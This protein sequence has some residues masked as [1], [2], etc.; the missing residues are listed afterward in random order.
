MI[1]ERGF[2]ARRV[3]RFPL[4]LLMGL[5]LVF[6][7]FSSRPAAA[8]DSVLLEE[9]RFNLEASLDQGELLPSPSQESK[10]EAARFLLEEARFIFSGMLY[11]FTFDYRP[12]DERFE[13][14]DEFSLTPVAGIP[15]GDEALSI[16]ESRMEDNTL[17]VQIRYDMKPFQQRRREAWDSGRIPSAAGIGAAPF[18]KGREQRYEAMKDGVRQAIRNHLR[19]RIFDRPRRIQGDVLFEE[20]PELFVKAG[21]YRARVQVRLKVREIQEDQLR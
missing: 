9:F 18:H 20:A 12:G 3:I 1:G 15:F 16:R 13:I 8:L 5:L 21:E 2:C 19:S 7:A 11:G 6:S 10:K 14:E 4:L 17:V